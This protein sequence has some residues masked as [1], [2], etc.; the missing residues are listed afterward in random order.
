MCCDYCK[1]FGVRNRHP[2]CLRCREWYG[3][4]ILRFEG[5]VEQDVGGDSNVVQ[6]NRAKNVLLTET[7]ITQC[8]QA[9]VNSIRWSP[10]I[11]ND[12]VSSF[13]NMV[14]RWF[15]VGTYRWT[16][17]N[18]RGTTLLSLNLPRDAIFAGQSTCNQPNTIPFR[19]HRYWRGDIR[20]KVH[21]NCN[22]FQ[23]GQLQLA[24]YYQ[25]KADDAF[26][27]RNNIYTGVVLIIQLYL[28][29]LIM[30]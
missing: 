25:P 26:S 18:A 8:D 3:E 21:I 7:E 10:Y 11:S 30:K 28:Q 17:Q 14:N 12:T 1:K 24:W 4:Q 2:T 9:G 22:K 13:D 29:L 6:Q 27:N 15:R 23:I 19:I 16:T 5:N 20:I